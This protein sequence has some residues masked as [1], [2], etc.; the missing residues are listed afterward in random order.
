MP[1]IKGRD[2]NGNYYRYGKSGKKFYYTTEDTRKQAKRKAILQ[3][4]VIERN[5]KYMF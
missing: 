5:R 4:W 2:K 1:I 3:G